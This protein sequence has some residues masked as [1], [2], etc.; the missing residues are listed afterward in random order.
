LSPRRAPAGISDPLVAD[1]LARAADTP[2][3]H[4]VRRAPTQPPVRILI[5]D[6][7]R[8]ALLGLAA[9]FGAARNCEV[10]AQATNAEQAVAQAQDHQ[11]DVVV[12][13][14]DLP[15]G[16]GIV[17]AQRIR[18]QN[19]VVG[20][21]IFGSVGEPN[22]VIAAIHAGVQGYLLKR[23]DPARLVEAV[24][25]VAGGSYVFD[26]ALISAIEDWFRAGRPTGGPPPLSQQER[27]ILRLVAEGKTNR[28]IADALHLSEYTV[29]TYV[30]A[31]LRK[32]GLASRAQA[33]AYIVND[34]A[35]T[36]E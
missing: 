10:V 2:A 8:V 29:K 13:D 35:Q 30:S 22:I 1:V 19:P 6:A 33:A 24:E 36:P 23:I 12:M 14:G 21:I 18:A 3:R 15:G 25:L 32:L 16:S 4:H 31:A 17:A 9:L 7:E 28:D 20:V 34:E 5:V 27:R 26:E 11:P